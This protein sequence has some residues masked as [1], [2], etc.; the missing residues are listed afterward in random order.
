MRRRKGSA[1]GKERSGLLV[2]AAENIEEGAGLV[3]ER[4][5]DVADRTAE[6][7]GGVLGSLKHGLTDAYTAGSKAV[8]EL[9]RLAHE[10]AERYNQNVEMKRL[11][12]RRDRLT[13]QL[14]Q[15]AYQCFASKKWPIEILSREKEAL[16][17][18]A[19]IEQLNQ[20]VIKI[21]KE[22]EQEKDSS[23]S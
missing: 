18:Y 22:L 11:T 2:E 5:V 23:S 4:I 10:Y 3:G 6:V 17:M 1:Q 16:V 21:G 12:V 8:D 13:A 15:V 20:E 9:T 19:E 7:A 14:G